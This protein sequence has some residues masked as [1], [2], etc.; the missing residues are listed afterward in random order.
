MT[1]TLI[2][3]IPAII[4]IPNFLKHYRTI[5]QVLLATISHSPESFSLPLYCYCCPFK[6]T[7]SVK[8][9]ISFLRYKALYSTLRYAIIPISHGW[10][11]LVTFGD[12]N[13]KH[14]R[15]GKKN[16]FMSWG[17]Q[18]SRVRIA[19]TFTWYY[20]WCVQK[21]FIIHQY[22]ISLSNHTFLEV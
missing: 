20:K 6:T 7:R 2:W 13:L 18:F 17:V 3:N 9:S 8:N 19:L 12:I 21:T 1:G 10:W 4:S 14:I 15:V 5:Q 16:C 22:V 11:L